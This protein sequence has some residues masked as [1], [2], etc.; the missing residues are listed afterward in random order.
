LAAKKVDVAQ[1]FYANF[2]G[3][4]VGVGEQEQRERTGG[5]TLHF[6]LASDGRERTEGK[7]GVRNK[8]GTIKAREADR[9]VR[10]SPLEERT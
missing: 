3:G 9:G 10:V 7:R 1:L 8:T 5:F 2:R 4:Q 6:G